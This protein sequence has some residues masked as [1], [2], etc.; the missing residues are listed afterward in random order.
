V[1]HYLKKYKTQCWSLSIILFTSIVC[2]IPT[3]AK[4]LFLNTGLLGT[5]VSRVA[6]DKTGAA[7]DFFNEKYWTLGASLDLE[8]ET[9][10]L[11]PHLTFTP[12][13]RLTQDEAAKVYL[14]V[15][16]AN[17]GAA[18]GP[19]DF[20][21]GPGLMFN[22]VS[23]LGGVVS[24]NNGTSS[25]DFYRPIRSSTSRLFIIDFLFGI[26]FV[27]WLRWDTGMWV[28]GAFT[29]RRALNFYTSIGVGIF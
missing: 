1:L 16:S 11:V 25:R 19:F 13:G 22:T 27:D 3:K 7:N 17:Y 12:I 28:T 23:G 6:T 14:F 10:R 15:V 5:N 9:F 26:N 24:R 2:P 8:F 29:G 4:T 18:L 20:Q 21:I